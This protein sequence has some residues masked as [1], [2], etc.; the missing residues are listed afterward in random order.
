[1]RREAAIAEAMRRFDAADAP[2]RPVPAARRHRPALASLVAASLVLIVAVPIAWQRVRH[3]EAIVPQSA[4]EP[5]RREPLAPPRNAANAPPS[6]IARAE[7]AAPERPVGPPP[8]PIVAPPPPIQLTFAPAP[9]QDVV[10]PPAPAPAPPPPAMMAAPQSADAARSEEGNVIVTAARRR[11]GPGYRATAGDWNA[12]TI[13][14]PRHNLDACRR[15]LTRGAHEAAAPLSEGLTRAWQ[16]DHDQAL[17]AFDRAVAAA[18]KSALARLNRGLT[19]RDLGDTA[20][21]LADLAEAA[22]LAPFSARVH[23]ALGRIARASGDQRRA[24]SEF[25]RAA[26]L[27]PDYD[28]LEE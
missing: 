5:A 23:F 21:A 12:C 26:E 16:G 25:A 22:R 11:S 3:G 27:D 24:R 15:E 4:D 6:Q 19:K 14:D 9:I 20:G 7:P 8:P 1:M 2:P 28:G 18:P 17:E 13:D 10:T